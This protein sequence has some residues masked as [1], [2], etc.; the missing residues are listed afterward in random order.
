M[1]GEI[2]PKL[3][4]GSEIVG[5]IVKGDLGGFQWTTLAMRGEINNKLEKKYSKNKIEL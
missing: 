2:V 5:P 1:R 4:V 3:L